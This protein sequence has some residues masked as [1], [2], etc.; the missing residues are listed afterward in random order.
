MRVG[1]G[2][3]QRNACRQSVV[4]PDL[5]NVGNQFRL[6]IQVFPRRFAPIVGIVFE[7][8]EGEILQPI[9]R[10]EVLEKSSEP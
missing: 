7:R 3:E 10:F 5:H 9:M 1:F 8:H 4:A 6:L 2:I